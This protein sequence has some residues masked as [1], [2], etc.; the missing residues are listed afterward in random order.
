MRLEKLRACIDLSRVHGT[1]IIMGIFLVGILSGRGQVGF[2]DLLL[3]AV[4]IIFYKTSGAVLNDLTDFELDSRDPTLKNKPLQSGAI[5]KRSARAYLAFCFLTG[6]TLSVVFLPSAATGMA[7]LALC[8]GYAYNLWG[9]FG[10]VTFELLFPASMGILVLAGSFVSGGPT[11]VT[12]VLAYIIFLA[13]VFAQWI[14]A[15]RDLDCDRQNGVG[16]LAAMVSLSA[17]NGGKRDP[18]RQFGQFVWMM[19]TMSL[20]LPFALHL[21]PWAYLFPVLAIHGAVSV[22]IYTALSKATTR[23]D[24]NIV[25]VIHVVACW[26]PIPFFLLDKE[27]FVAPT[28]LMLFV[29]LGTF[30]AIAAEK[31]SQYKLALA[32]NSRGASAPKT[33]DA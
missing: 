20:I 9:K 33:E 3:G 6:F 29:V 10:P 28:G 25:L 18:V 27:G 22:A 24:F 2:T 30:L 11:P 23:R 26:F 5:S 16:S 17:E 13:N 1:P 15:L 31:K 8:L 14:N 19:Y 4:V 12:F 7:V 32:G 21:L